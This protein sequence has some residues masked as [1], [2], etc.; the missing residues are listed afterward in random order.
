MSRKRRPFAAV[1]RARAP[2]QLR[3]AKRFKLFE[4]RGERLP[5]VRRGRILGR[6]RQKRAP[7]VVEADAS[8]ACAEL[9]RECAGEGGRCGGCRCGHAHAS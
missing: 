6:H 7:H 2:R 3:E 4:A 5:A 1:E 9:G 8:A